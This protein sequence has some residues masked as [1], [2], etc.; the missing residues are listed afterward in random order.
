MA[1]DWNVDEIGFKSQVG[2]SFRAEMS[3][4]V[5]D[6]NSNPSGRNAPKAVTTSSL[7]TFEPVRKMGSPKHCRVQLSVVTRMAIHERA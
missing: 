3:T 4:L 5:A 6:E 2:Q 7:V 1:I